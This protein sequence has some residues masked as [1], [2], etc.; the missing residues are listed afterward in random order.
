MAEHCMNILC[1]FK[2]PVH[3]S[4]SISSNWEM[5]KLDEMFLV[6]NSQQ[7]SRYCVKIWRQTGLILNEFYE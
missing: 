6:Q 5:K 1:K 3:H 2:I 4:S 7:K